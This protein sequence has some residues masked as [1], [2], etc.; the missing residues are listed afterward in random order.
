[1]EYL[2]ELDRGLFNLLNGILRADWL[3]A[4]APYLR[5]PET[6][7]PLYLFLI[8]FIIYRLRKLGFLIV[9]VA[10][11]TVGLADYTS[12]SIVKPTVERLRPCKDPI[13]NQYAVLLISCG[14]GYSFTS[15]HA[16]N[17]FC[18]AV[19]LLLVCGNIFGRWRWLLLA[20]AALVSYAQ[21]YVGVHFPLDILGGALLGS[22]LAWL[23]SR[24]VAFLARRYLQTE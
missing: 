14:S 19:F 10:G 18:L 17:H 6:W 1:M 3:D 7:I 15:S 12:S 22:G 11:M 24:L 5:T 8:V 16:T 13:V 20:W 9:L 2:L 21:I 23:G 4:V